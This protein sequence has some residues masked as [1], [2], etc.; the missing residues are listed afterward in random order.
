MGLDLLHDP[1]FNK[2]TAFTEEERDLLRLRG[3]LP[4]RV[5]APEL[6]EARVMENFRQT[7]TDLQKYI[8]LIALLD[9][10]ETLFYRILSHHVAE[11]MP[12][13][14]TPTVGAAVQRFSALPS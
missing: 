10:N 5:F 7:E 14:Y 1:V 9:R 6:Q 4:P 11:M 2:G 8:F 3:L 12:I 13:V